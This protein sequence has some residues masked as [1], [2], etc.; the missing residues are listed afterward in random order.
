MLGHWPSMTFGRLTSTIRPC[1]FSLKRFRI[2]SLGLIDVRPIG[3]CRSAT[4]CLKLSNIRLFGLSDIR[5]FGPTN[6]RP[7]DGHKRFV[8]AETLKTGRILLDLVDVHPRTPKTSKDTLPLVDVRPRTPRTSN[9]HTPRPG[10]RPF[11]TARPSMATSAQAFGRSFDPTNIRLFGLK[12]IRPL[13]STARPS[14]ATAQV[15][16]RSSQLM[17]GH[18]ASMTSVLLSSIVRPFGLTDVRSLVRPLVSTARSFMATSAQ[19]FGRS[20]PLI[21][22]RSASKVFALWFQPLDHPWPRALKYSAVRPN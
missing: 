3:L 2:R 17:F 22:G 14:M 11:S 6:V 10:I 4:R 19:A 13:V 15:F 16:D 12:G 21:F 7:P 5:P 20:T 18:P 9:Y 1:N 8:H